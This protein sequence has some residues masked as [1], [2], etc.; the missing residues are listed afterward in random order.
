MRIAELILVLC[1]LLWAC[2]ASNTVARKTVLASNLFDGTKKKTSTVL[3][4]GA[5]KCNRKRHLSCYDNNTLSEAKR[6]VPTGPNPL[7]N[8]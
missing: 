1:L 5:H 2:I 3:P 8:R 6:L 4:G 7:H